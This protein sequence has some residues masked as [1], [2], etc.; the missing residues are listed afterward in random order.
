M[1]E[2]L[3]DFG[4]NASIVPVDVDASYA[5][6]RCLPSCEYQVPHVSH[7]SRGHGKGF[8]ER[9]AAP[10]GRPLHYCSKHSLFKKTF[11]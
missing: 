5:G 3:T 4:K 6:K 7:D 1:E 8:V 9:T 2:F 11:P 10:A